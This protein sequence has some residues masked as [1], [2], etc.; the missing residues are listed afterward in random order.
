[1]NISAYIDCKSLAEYARSL[2]NVLFADENLSMCTTAGADFI[3]KYMAEYKLNRI[4]VGACTPK[5]HEPV[6]RA[7]L[8]DAGLDQSYLEFVNL[9]E[10]ISLVHQKDRY[11]AFEMAK[12]MIRAGVA[13]AAKLEIVPERVVPITKA[14]MVIGGG[15]AGIQSSLDLANQGYKVYL[16]EEKP[17][18]G[19]KMAMLDRTFPTDDC[20]I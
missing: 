7:I 10:Q 17:T 16:V 8:K 14:V 12:D 5:T 3:K 18:I 4:V 15:V 13:R 11:G 2:P 1:V 9:R 20:S 19:G 6:F